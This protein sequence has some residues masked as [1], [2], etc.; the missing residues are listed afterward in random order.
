MGRHEGRQ[1]LGGCRLGRTRTLA[2]LTAPVLAGAL[3]LVPA[4]SPTGAAGAASQSSKTRVGFTPEVPAA[5]TA[6]SPLASTTSLSVDVVLQPRD[7]G[8]LSSYAHAVST[9]GTSAYEH[10]LTEPQFVARYAPTPATIAA[11]RKALV[12]A[13]LQPGATSGDDLSIPVRATSAKLSSAFGVGFRQY[14]VARGRIAYANTAP[15]Q[16]A[17]SVAPFVQSIV[18][19]DDLNLAMP[20]DAAPVTGSRAA[21]AAVPAATSGPKACTAAKNAALN[22]GSFTT[23]QVGTA[24]GFPSLYSRGDLGAGQ[25]V[26]LYELQKYSSPDV[27]AYKSCF[28][29]KTATSTWNVDGGPLANSGVVESDLDIEQ[30]MGLAPG[31]HLFIYQGPNDG[32]GGYDTYKA[33]ISGDQAKVISTSWGLCEP[34]TGSSAAQAEGTLFQEAAVQGQTIVAASGDQ[35]SEDCLGSNESN[36]GLAVDDPASQPYVTGVGGTAW[37]AYGSPPTETTW[38]FGPGCCSGAGG[39]GVSKLWKMPSYQTDAAGTGVLNAYSS[40]TPC[41]ATA[42][43]YCREV[44]D[45]SALADTIYLQYVDGGWQSWGGTSLAAPLWAAFFALSDASPTCSGRA[46]GFANPLLYEV[47]AAEPSAFHDVTVG[48]NDLTGKNSGKYPA[49]G[50]YDM[51]TGL[52]TPNVSL[53]SSALCESAPSDPVSATNPGAQQSKLDAAVRLQIRATAGAGAGALTY[54]AVGL[55]AGVGI[56]ASTGL[57]SG[58][59]TSWGS[60]SVYVSV[61]AA[62]GASASTSFG[63]NVAVAILSA[64][65]ATAVIGKPFSFTVRPTGNPTSLT[66][67]PKPPAP[68]TFKREKNGTATLSGTPTAKTKT[69][70]YHLT[71]DAVYGSGGSRASASQAFVLTVAK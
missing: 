6:V 36:D 44:P 45:V 34:F 27:S 60:S 10:Y 43:S 58:A 19:L 48:T 61:R 21:E 59:P 53:L 11:V 51:A 4:A 41:G 3:L 12:E 20:A 25:A 54:R 23:D 67:L 31:V 38:N 40:G 18:G 56:N 71:V 47:A 70:T 24:Y 35:G 63:W 57:I 66:V 26:A 16:L 32:A 64:N 42:G 49:L 69:G 2:V 37:T 8:A 13:G 65:H 5:A 55:P 17:R 14:R 33:I 39:G 30:V 7:P 62:S 9:P 22:Q 29:V 52:G 28:G 68:F 1:F 15:P 46:I 50:G